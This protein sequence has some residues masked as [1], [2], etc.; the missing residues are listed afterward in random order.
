MDKKHL[1]REIL[2]KVSSKERLLKLMEIFQNE[3]NEENKL[4]IDDTVTRLHN[5]YSKKSYEFKVDRKTIQSDIKKLISSGFSIDICIGKMGKKLYYYCG[6]TLDMHE[7]RILL[8]AVYSAKSITNKERDNLIKKIK[9]L[10]NKGDSEIYDSKLYIS[11]PVISENTYLK[12][13]L[14]KIH[15][16]IFNHTKLKFK[17]GNYDT[18]KNF[19]LH[20]DGDFY[21]VYPYNLVWSN[22]FYYLV[23]YD[24]KKEK[25]INYR[26]DRMR[27]VELEKE[28]FGFNN[29]FD[30][31]AYLKT[32]FNMYPG[33]VSTVEIKFKNKL[34]NAIIDRFGKE[35]NIVNK[36]DKDFIIKFEAAVNEGLL[37]WILNWG[38]EAQVISPHYL[39]DMMREEIAKIS[40]IYV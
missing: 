15:K 6:E 5:E 1:L 40:N 30:I 35:V 27:D 20:H 4:S 28:N 9:S 11:Q 38:A 36:N 17:Y 10:T 12:Y 3:T 13:Y 32:C 23:A 7:I 37:R 2:M 18:N 16:A 33:H 26:V 21:I 14:D 25:I 8:D 31:N 24:E 39:K 29:E 34:I 22:D 19:N